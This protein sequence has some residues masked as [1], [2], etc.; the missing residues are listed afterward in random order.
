[1][2]VIKNVRILDPASATDMTG[3]IG[4]ENGKITA[5]GT[6]ET[7]AEDQVLDGKGLVASP[8]LV[9]T[10]VHF[11]DPGLTYKE[12]IY[13]GA[14][15]AAAGGFTSVVCMANTKPVADNVDTVSYI[16]DKGKK[17]NIHVYA[18]AAVTKAFDGKNL[19]DFRDLLKAG[20]VGFT[21]DGIPIKD[22]KTVK[23]AMEL[24]AEL[25]VPISLH[26]ED[27]DLIE[28]PGVNQGKVSEKLNYGGAPARSEYEMVRRDCELT[29]QTRA[30]TV[31]QHISSAESVEAVRQCWRRGGR[32]YGE[33]TPQHFSATEDLVL[34]KGALARVN[35]PLRTEADRRAIIEGLKDGTLNIIATD[36]APHSREEKA[37]DI[38]DAPSGMIGLET[39]L[40][41]GITNLVKTGELE[42]IDLLEKMTINPAMLYHLN[43]G[44]VTEGG[45]ADLVLFDPDKKWTVE[46][47]FYSKANNSPFIGMELTGKV[48][49]TICGGK[50]VYQAG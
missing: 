21:D 30:K 1:M 48:Q 32:I 22:A 24:A 7:K 35:P 29:L 27:P 19:T 20:A 5:I 6:V 49:Y 2:F 31:I 39:S 40:A 18:T 43:A 14:H 23:A 10:H 34:E 26:E 37:K 15:A 16:V 28:R 11:R 17:T 4:I 45:P 41:L 38:K 12:D 8:G 42:L 13:S 3:D 47:H 50:I 25:D 9:D 36:H 44:R 33:V 46:D